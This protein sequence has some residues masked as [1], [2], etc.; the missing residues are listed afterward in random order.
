[1]KSLRV[2]SLVCLL[3][4]TSYSVAFASEGGAPNW[5]DLGLRVINLILFVGILWWLAGKILVSALSGRR[6]AIAN[7][8]ADIER[9]KQ[10]AEAQM[11]AV[12]QRIAGVEAE[13]DA[14]LA[15]SK[16]QAEIMKR[17]LL[18]DAEN[19]AQQ[20]LDQARKTAENDARAM[21]AKVRSALAEELAGQIE[22]SLAHKL[23][24][25]AHERLIDSMLKKVVVQ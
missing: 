6:N 23:D 19:Q 4:L 16:A 11:A 15:E 9:Q 1:M 3:S 10:E 24:A 22:Q 17:N 14:I 2:V 5:T 7:A 13:R 25:T 21:V 20:I 12:A 8:L 18:A